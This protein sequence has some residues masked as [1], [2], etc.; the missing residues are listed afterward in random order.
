MSINTSCIKI[1]GLCKLVFIWPDELFWNMKINILDKHFSVFI[2]ST[3]LKNR[4]NSAYFYREIN[5]A[6]FDTNISYIVEK[7]KEIN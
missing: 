7:L 6:L 1:L 3:T 4:E 2:F 5:L